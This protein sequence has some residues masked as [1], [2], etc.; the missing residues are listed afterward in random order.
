MSELKVSVINKEIRLEDRIEIYGENRKTIVKS[1]NRI[2]SIRV[3][4][5]L[6]SNSPIQILRNENNETVKIKNRM[7]GLVLKSSSDVAKPQDSIKF[8]ITENGESHVETIQVVDTDRGEP[9]FIIDFYLVDGSLDDASI[10][11]AYDSG[12]DVNYKDISKIL[13]DSS[14]AQKVGKGQFRDV[15]RIDRN[16]FDFTSEMG[17]GCIVKVARLHRGVKA[18]QSEMQTWQAVKSTDNRSLFCPVRSAGPN[19]N[20][21]VMDEASNIGSLDINIIN[22]IEQAVK[23]SFETDFSEYNESHPL[24][25]SGWDVKRSNV[26]VYKGRP[27]LVD[28]PYGGRFRVQ[29][30]ESRDLIQQILRQNI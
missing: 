27:V 12:S 5:G 24:A 21:I 10:P 14:D 13:S 1:G 29:S 3:D 26:G 20:Y 7:S 6:N 17:K 8:S 19:H 11:T 4:Y 15:Y 23:K 28:Y 9:L 25:M 16:R 22:K 18:N 30:E 2:S